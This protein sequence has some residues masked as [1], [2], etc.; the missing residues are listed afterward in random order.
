MQTTVDDCFSLSSNSR[1]CVEFPGKSFSI[2]GLEKHSLLAISDMLAIK[3]KQL[4]AKQ[5]TL[6]LTTKALSLIRQRDLPRLQPRARVAAAA[7]WLGNA[8]GE[9]FSRHTPISAL[10]NSGIAANF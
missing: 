4:W 5:I 7:C 3:I 9:Q 1:L 2:F 10:S 8:T 6:G